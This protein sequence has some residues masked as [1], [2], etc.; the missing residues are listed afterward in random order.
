MK[1]NRKKRSI[2]WK[3]LIGILLFLS[4]LFSIGYAVACMIRSPSVAPPGDPHAKV[5]SDYT[6][7]L[8][9]CMTAIL[10]MFLPSALE[11]RF[12][13]EIPNYMVVL[14][15][16]FLYCAVYLGEVRNFYY[17]VPHWDT[18][19]HGF[20]GAMLGALGFVLVNLLNDA[21]NVKMSLSPGFVAFFAFC[22]ALACGAVWE[23]YE[24][25]M[26]GLL[27][28]NMQ[29]FAIEDGTPLMGRA[30]LLDTMK[31]L[32]VDALGALVIAVIGYFPLRWPKDRT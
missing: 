17:A 26:D 19:L 5:K 8:V 1:Q 21:P 11:R 7:M 25:L 10:V 3:K 12:R 20:S 9:Q 29:H 14:Y 18:I 13:L 28:M 31:D 24:Y 32:I 30:A 22:F 16:A 27:H 6:L 15:F 23:I 4:L 2:S